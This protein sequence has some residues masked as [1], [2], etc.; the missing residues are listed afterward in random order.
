[1]AT[2]TKVSME[3]TETSGGRK[4]KTC[5][6][7]NKS[8]SA[9]EI[10]GLRRSNAEVSK[11]ATDQSTRT[12]ADGKQ[13]NPVGQHLDKVASKLAAAAAGSDSHQTVEMQTKDGEFKA[14]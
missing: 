1:M 6:T 14:C 5:A 11:Q 2:G 13:G 4:C 7:D 9:C 8:K 10:C 3:D 12:G